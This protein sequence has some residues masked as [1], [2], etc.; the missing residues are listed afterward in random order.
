MLN[1]ETTHSGEKHYKCAECQKA[2]ARESNLALHM[3][4]HEVSNTDET[5]AYTCTICKKDFETEVSLLAH[6]ALCMAGKPFR[7]MAYDDMFARSNEI[8]SLEETADACAAEVV[9]TID[10]SGDINS[11]EISA[12][13]NDQGSNDNT[14]MTE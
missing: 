12:L 13:V 5:K 2:F 9:V 1:H 3:K 6:K 7:F 10:S 4:T 14:C 11:V 8:S